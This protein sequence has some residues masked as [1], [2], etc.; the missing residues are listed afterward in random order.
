VGYLLLG[1]KL[2]Q[3]PQKFGGAFNFG[4]FPEDMIS[5]EK[6]TQLALAAWGGGTYQVQSNPGQ[7]HEA[8]LLT[9]SIDKAREELSWTPKLNSQQA[10]QWSIE[11][12][13]KQ[14]LGEDVTQLMQD[15]IVQYLAL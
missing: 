1:I 3:N 12:Y 8:G 2:K 11:W 15:Q 5:V 7:L 13:K 4:P 14:H 10:I 6:M 9:L